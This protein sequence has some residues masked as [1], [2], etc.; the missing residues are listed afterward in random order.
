MLTAVLWT[1]TSS[2]AQRQALL[3]SHF[4][5][6]D[7]FWP[8]FLHC[9]LYL[10]SL[11]VWFLLQTPAWCES[12]PCWESCE[13]GVLCPS[14][15]SHTS[16]S[17]K[18]PGSLSKGLLHLVEM[19]QCQFPYPLSNVPFLQFLFFNQPVGLFSFIPHPRVTIHPYPIHWFQGPPLHVIN[20][21]TINWEWNWMKQNY[22]QLLCL[23]L[24][25][26]LFVVR[27]RDPLLRV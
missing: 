25:I 27:N 18:S 16:D 3:E 5:S 22:K 2:F 19:G 8:C 1:F 7:P 11:L 13:P 9:L 21:N 15:R 12:P 10:W 4:L 24:P 26:M 23:F 20:N 14:S 17:Q 6:C